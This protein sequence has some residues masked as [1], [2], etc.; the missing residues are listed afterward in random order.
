MSGLQS[1]PCKPPARFRRYERIV[2]SCP[3]SAT[4]EQ[5]NDQPGTVVWCDPYWL[6]V[7]DARRRE[8]MYV[9]HLENLSK[10]VTFSESDLASTGAFE[11]ESAFLGK[12]PEISFDV[13][14]NDDMPFVE[15]TYRLP[16]R[17]W[18]VLIMAHED[19]PALQ[20]KS[21]TWPSGI[22]GL[23]FTVPATVKIDRQ[24]VFRT[25]AEAC[26]CDGWLEAKG[27]DSMVLR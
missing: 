24:F 1:E 9:V 17:F 10:Y 8:W 13:I 7:K 3:V 11:P 4:R 15:G 22:T 27:P 23:V 2:V 5:F 21:S 16:G 19:V 25:M 12:Q 18:Q 14:M 20:V 26:S 6:S